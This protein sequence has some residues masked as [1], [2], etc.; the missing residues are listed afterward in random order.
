VRVPARAR[1]W[2][3]VSAA[4]CP[5]GDCLYIADIGD[6]RL[7]RRTIE[8]YRVPEPA[9]ADAETREPEVFH[10]TY[11]DGPHNAEALFVTGSDAFIVTRDRVGGL[12]RAAL[13]PAG[14]NIV[15]QRTGQLALGAVTDAEAFDAGRAV[16]VRTSHEAV[17]YRIAE[18]SRGNTTADFRI[19]LDG[20]REPQGEGV[21][22]DGSMLY[23]SSEGRRWNSGGWFMSLNCQFPSTVREGTPPGPPSRHPSGAD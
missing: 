19:S 18:L 13:P 17:L 23:L 7:T 5:L 9:P 11:A 16:V 6:N 12:Y 22:V 1:D 21:A 3:D 15:F 10:A 14:G 2:E 4:A 20:L 8:I